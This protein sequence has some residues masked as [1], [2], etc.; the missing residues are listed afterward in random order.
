MDMAEDSLLLMIRCTNKVGNDTFPLDWEDLDVPN[1]CLFLALLFHFDEHR[2]N[3]LQDCWRVEPFGDPCVK[4][5]GISYRKF[6][7]WYKCV[8][9][10]DPASITDSMK[11]HDK[12][13]KIRE[14]LHSVEAS[15]QRMY[16]PPDP[17]F[18]LDEEMA[19]YLVR[20]SQVTSLRH[21]WLALVTVCV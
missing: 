7:C 2:Q 20:Q 3:D 5:V 4:A 1:M 11:Q 6:R 18:S 8:R 21:Y 19:G 12:A 13:Y 15:C 14:Y 10:Y 16:N 17:N 9:L